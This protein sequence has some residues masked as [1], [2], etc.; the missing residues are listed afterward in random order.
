M[1]HNYSAYNTF[2]V[3]ISDLAY[4]DRENVLAVYINTQE[5]EGWWYQGDGIYRDVRLVVTDPVAID[6]W[7]VYAPS[8]KTG[9]PAS[10][11]G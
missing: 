5:F 11:I 6:L 8:R 3:D 1:H 4:R 7:G 10:D 2:E 9:N